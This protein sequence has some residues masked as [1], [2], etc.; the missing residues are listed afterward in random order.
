M[1]VQHGRAGVVAIDGGLNLMP[2]TMAVLQDLASYD[3]VASALQA[4]RT[5]SPILPRLRVDDDDS[6]AFLMPGDPG[7]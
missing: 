5:I 2:P 3:D 1:H 4:E 6:M 7:Y